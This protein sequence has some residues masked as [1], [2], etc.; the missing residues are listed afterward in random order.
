M[1]SLLSEGST[2]PLKILVFVTKSLKAKKLYFLT[3]IATYHETC[4]IL[5]LFKP[6]ECVFFLKPSGFI[7]STGFWGEVAFR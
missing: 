5:L 7:M 1:D 2:L 4:T 6:C 3:V